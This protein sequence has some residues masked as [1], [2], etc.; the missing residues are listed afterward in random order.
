VVKPAPKRDRGKTFLLDRIDVDTWARAKARAETEG[1]TMRGLILW[2][3]TK[4]A[5]GKIR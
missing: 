3:L 4:Y 5:E 1:R 2:L